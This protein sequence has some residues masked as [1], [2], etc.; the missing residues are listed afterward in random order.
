MYPGRTITKGTHL[1]SKINDIE[2]NEYKTLSYEKI[3]PYL[4]DEI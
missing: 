4:V 1:I 2:G 3:V